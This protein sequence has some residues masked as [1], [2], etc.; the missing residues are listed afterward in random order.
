MRKQITLTLDNDLIKDIE[1]K[2]FREASERLEK[3]G[4]RQKVNLSQYIEKLIKKGL[5]KK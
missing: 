4:E 2:M 3:T 1:L 5:E